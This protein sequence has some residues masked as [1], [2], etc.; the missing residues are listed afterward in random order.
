MT[1]A[2]TFMLGEILFE[3]GLP[4]GVANVML[5]YGQ[6]VGSL[7]STHPSVDMVSF[8]GLTGVGKMIVAAT[9]STLQTPTLDQAADAI[10][11]GSISMPVSA[12]IPVLG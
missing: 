1:S 11:F 7:M 8:T 4:A 2:T 9:A 10:V 3:A 5:G 12:A 6:P